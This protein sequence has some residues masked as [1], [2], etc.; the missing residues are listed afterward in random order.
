MQVTC[1]LQKF[2]EVDGLEHTNTDYRMYSD[3]GKTTLV[4]EIID[5]PLVHV[6]IEVFIPVGET[7]YLEVTRR[8]NL[9]Y[10]DYVSELYEYTN[11]NDE[12]SNMLVS[13]PVTIDRP[14]VNVSKKSIVASD[15]R[16]TITTS[17]YRGVGDGHTHSNW[18]I[19]NKSNKL[20]FRELMSSNKTSIELPKSLVNDATNLT[21]AVQH[22]SN[23]IVSPLGKKRILFDRVNFDV[24]S[25]LTNIPL[26][27]YKLI[28]EKIDPTKNLKV[29]RVDVYDVNDTL[30]KTVSI[31]ADK[32]SVVVMIDRET[33]LSNLK[34]KVNVTGYTERGRVE[35]I[36]RT[37]VP[38]T[39][40]HSDCVDKEYKFS[41][42]LSTD[43]DT[44]YIMDYK[45]LSTDIVNGLNVLPEND[46]LRY[47]KFDY[48]TKKLLP[49]NILNG[50]TLLNDNNDGLFIKYLDTG[51]LI[52]DTID[53]DGKPTF[54]IYQHTI[55]KDTYVLKH[56]IT[57]VEETKSL[58]YTNSIVQLSREELMYGVVGT[59]IINK[60][61]VTTGEV[62]KVMT[63]GDGT[64]NTLIN[65]LDG[66][67]M[68]LSNNTHMSNIYRYN[69]STLM[70]GPSIPA[71]ELVNADLKA[72]RLINGDWLII[73]NNADVNKGVYYN[74]GEYTMTPLELEFPKGTGKNL[75][76]LSGEVAI[77]E[78]LIN[79]SINNLPTRTNIVRYK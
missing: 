49:R 35:Y 25:K 12:I 52:V 40:S 3:K 77:C 42:E 28:I 39:Y 32:E 53:D 57:R 50:V 72:L 58:G 54:L 51:V 64:N 19:F 65:L 16:F 55:Y 29:G 71:G 8:F 76:P 37:L 73:S 21:F 47:F 74:S 45:D 1:K 75:L 59:N 18:F 17:G 79:D 26:D 34:L 30:V 14:I 38:I 69:T 33:V 4:K 5:G 78:K 36:S 7:Y 41:N 9:P 70:D 13:T 10:I 2:I 56:K 66:R 11:N 67:I 20:I 15:E 60:I 63:V 6:A 24:T 31:D 22:C 48:L 61:N 46:K 44:D 23:N 27:N 62:T 43:Y 68:I